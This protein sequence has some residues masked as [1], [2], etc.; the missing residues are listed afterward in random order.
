MFKDL[1][2]AVF[3]HLSQLVNTITTFANGFLN[4]SID[5]LYKQQTKKRRQKAVLS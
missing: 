4:S 3:A 2:S 1:T 5:H